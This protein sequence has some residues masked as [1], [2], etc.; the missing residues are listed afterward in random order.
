[1]EFIPLFF[2]VGLVLA[3]L[4]SMGIGARAGSVSWSGAADAQPPGTK[5]I[6]SAGNGAGPAEN[7][8]RAARS[9]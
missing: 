6:E 7:D 8:V 9:R 4:R 5:A 3:G 2:L 1:V